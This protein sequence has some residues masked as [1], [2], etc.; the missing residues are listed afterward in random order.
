M[1]TPRFSDIIAIYHSA[2]L[3]FI[4]LHFFAPPLNIFFRYSRRCHTAFY[5]SRH[6]AA[7]Y[8]RQRRRSAAAE[9]FPGFLRCHAASHAALLILI[10]LSAISSFF[11]FFLSPEIFSALL[12]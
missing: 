12:Q 7:P 8:C 10:W 3:H 2:M 9:R 1:S 4:T 11:I 5:R 6:A